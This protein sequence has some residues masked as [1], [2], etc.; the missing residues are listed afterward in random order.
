MF[1]IPQIKSLREQMLNYPVEFVPENVASYT[2]KS[3]NRIYLKTNFEKVAYNPKTKERSV[4]KLS[5]E[6]FFEAYLTFDISKY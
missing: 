1:E 5:E 2:D 4:I 3:G 6:E